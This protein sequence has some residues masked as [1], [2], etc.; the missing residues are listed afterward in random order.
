M[1][2]VSETPHFSRIPKELSA[3]KRILI[4]SE[5]IITDKY[6]SDFINIGMIWN[7]AVCYRGQARTLYAMASLEI[8]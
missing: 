7:V 1:R 2:G 3:L 5:L 8:I 4:F 6:Y